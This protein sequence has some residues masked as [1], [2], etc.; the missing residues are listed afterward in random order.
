VVISHS[1]CPTHLHLASTKHLATAERA[2]QR[3][4][5]K[6]TDI[7]QTQQARFLPFSL[8]TTGGIGKDAEELI[9]QISLASR[10]NL[11]L[12]SHHHIAHT[13]RASIAIAIQRGNALA[14][15]GGYSRGV[16]RAGQPHA[17]A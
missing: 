6:Y 12:P 2:E 14:V 4:H 11:L 9:D 10:D 1:L 5:R 13:I 15:Y 7:A 8:E 3:K 16:L 17:A